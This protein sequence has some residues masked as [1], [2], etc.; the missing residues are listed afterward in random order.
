MANIKEIGENAL[1]QIESLVDKK[2]EAVISVTRENEEWRVRTELLERRAVPDT[3]DILGIYELRLTDD[4]ELTGYKRI[5][6]RRRAD[7][8]IEEEE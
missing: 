8:N 4:G 1:A 6:L 3:Q 5:G 7:L 2:A